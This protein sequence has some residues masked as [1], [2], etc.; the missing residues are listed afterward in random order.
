MRWLA[1]VLVAAC[2]AEPVDP[3]LGPAAAED[4]SWHDAPLEQG[5]RYLRDRGYRRSILEA[6]VVDPT[7][8]Y[9][10]V[11]LA[12]YALDRGG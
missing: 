8:L 6:S 9:S 10:A 1:L 11:R 2:A 3:G 12:N 5:H 7:N 4:A